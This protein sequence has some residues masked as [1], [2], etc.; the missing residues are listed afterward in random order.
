MAR[1]GVSDV[2]EVEADP[3]AAALTR[4][5]VFD[6]SDIDGMLTTLEEALPIRIIHW[7]DGAIFIRG[8]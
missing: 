3:L 1:G 6:S 2:T 7:P 4:S 5:A 8:R